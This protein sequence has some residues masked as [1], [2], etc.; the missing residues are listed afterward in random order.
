[1]T[2]RYSTKDVIRRT[3]Y[4]GPLIPRAR[5]RMMARRKGETEPFLVKYLEHFSDTSPNRLKQ[6]LIDMADMIDIKG[7]AEYWPEQIV[8]KRNGHVWV[9]MQ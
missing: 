1:L 2:D 5:Y 8:M 6:S 7:I 9:E 4:D 3:G